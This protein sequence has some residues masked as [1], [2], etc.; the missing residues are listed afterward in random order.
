MFS[1]FKRQK[2]TIDS[3]TIP[4]FGWT[5]TDDTKSKVQW[6][7]PEQTVAISVNFFNL[8]PD[9]PTIKRIDTLRD[10]YRNSIASINGGL[11]EVEL[12]KIANIPFARTIFKIPQEPSGM[13]YLA[14]LTIPF[15]TCSF[16]LKVQG[17]E[18]GITGMRDTMVANR[19]LGKGD[20]TIGK[21]GYENWFSDP[22]DNNFTDGTLMNKSEQT[23]YDKDFP[24]HPLTLVR[25]IIDEFESGLLFKPEIEKLNTLIK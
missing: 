1:F 3:V 6:I 14:S 20:L 12:R 23:V 16:V 17:F 19:L 4:N 9:I 18:D 10:F 22:Y 24:N 21:N 15:E 25:T 8:P 5:K 2:V 13:T 7:N 11:I